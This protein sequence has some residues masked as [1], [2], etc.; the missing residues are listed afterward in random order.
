MITIISP[1]KSLD[2]ESEVPCPDFTVPERLEESTQLMGKLKKLSAR[3]IGKLMGISPALAE[4]NYNRN[5]DW[6]PEFSPD[7]S[8]QAV[9]AFKG[10]V[11]RG[12]DIDSFH[13]DDVQYAQE[14]LR[15][16]SGLHG[17]LRPLDLIRPY[18]LEMGS[19][20]QVTKAK[21]NLYKYWGSKITDAINSQLERHDEKVL[22]NL[23]SSEYFKVVDFSGINGRVVTP[24]FKDLKNGS[25]KVI[26]TWAKLA[27][28]MMSAYIMKDRID[29]IEGLKSFAIEGYTY[30]E[31]S[32]TDEELV[33][34][35]G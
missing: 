27:R 22:V 32:S 3:Q 18:R 15:I 35:R 11:Y 29:T 21:N 31:A 16:L 28:G 33:F 26:M 19:R 10:D 24:V 25:Y 2:F 23:A 13:P 7:N 8:R 17:L 6:E 34:L 9:F 20:F 5:Q 12:L 14:H 30:D 4:L 1:A